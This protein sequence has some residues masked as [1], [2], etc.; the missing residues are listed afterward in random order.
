MICYAIFNFSSY[1][2]SF[3]IYGHISNFY[4]FT[5]MELINIAK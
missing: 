5:F 3:K 1:Y 4:G 2:I